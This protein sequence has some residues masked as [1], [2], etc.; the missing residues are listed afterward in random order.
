VYGSYTDK[1]NG[2]KRRVDTLK[3]FATLTDQSLYDRIARVGDER[4]C[5]VMCHVAKAGNIKDKGGALYRYAV[6]ETLSDNQLDTARAE[7]K[8]ILGWAR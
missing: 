6:V 3:Q 1:R 7:M 2:Y 8:R 4:L 5:A